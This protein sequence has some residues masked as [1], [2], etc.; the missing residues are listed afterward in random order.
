MKGIYF[1][2]ILAIGNLLFGAAALAFAGLRA[3]GWA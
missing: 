2:G 1:I 3:V